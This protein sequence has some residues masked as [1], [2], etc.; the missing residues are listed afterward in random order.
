VNGMIR[1][2]TWRCSSPPV[3]LM[4]V[5]T[6][7]LEHTRDGRDTQG[8]SK[9]LNLRSDLVVA[10]VDQPTNLRILMEVCFRWDHGMIL[11]FN[12]FSLV[13]PSID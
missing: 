6:Y 12:C 11:Y 7:D 10:K 5:R 13:L 9:C 2:K 1:A 3:A 4:S 8:W